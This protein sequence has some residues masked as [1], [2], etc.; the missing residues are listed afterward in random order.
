MVYNRNGDIFIRRMVV[1]V[2]GSVY[3]EKALDHAIMLAKV[4]GAEMQ[5]VHAIRHA[6]ITKTI[7]TQHFRL[8]QRFQQTN[9]M[10]V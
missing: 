10:K 7:L 4:F 3:S 1:A 8:E 2:D 5:I 6:E 9:C